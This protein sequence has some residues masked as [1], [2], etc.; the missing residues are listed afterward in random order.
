GATD[1]GITMF[2]KLV[3][4]GIEA[5]KEGR[6][7]DVL[8][9]DEKPVSTYCN[10]TVVYSPA[11]GNLEEDIEMMRETGRKLAEEYIKNPPLSK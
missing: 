2:R 3:R 10:D 1:R 7:P 6:D 9:R 8:S 11:V 4:Q 5:V